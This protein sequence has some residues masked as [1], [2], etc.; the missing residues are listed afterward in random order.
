[1]KKLSESKSAMADPAQWHLSRSFAFE[2]QHVA[3]DVRGNGPAVVL[4]HGT[5]WSSFNWRK[6]I[7]ALARHH[8]VYFY[9]LLGFGQSQKSAGQDVSLRI[10]GRLL[11]RLI[12]HWGL[13]RPMVVG[14]DFGGT[15][16]LRS[17]LLEGIE[18][19]KMAL[20]DPVAV[21]PWGSPF[22]KH[23]KVH[24]A[25]FSGVPSYIH[26][27]MVEAYVRGAMHQTPQPEALAGILRP[28]LSEEGQAAFYRQI[29]QADQQY[30]DEI[31]PLYGAITCK[32]LLVWGEE[33][34][35]VPI[36]KGH[37]LNRMIPGSRL[38]PLP[39]A[40]HLVQEDAPQLLADVLV[41]YFN[42]S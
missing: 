17:H 15:T 10:Q 34:T 4:V 11:A 19:A 20:V 2:A 38:V 16:V 22:F 23:V 30:T 39:A 13:V 33:D 6:I 26:A 35:W 40:G 28:W 37:A 1:M 3:Y 21:G 9:D 32:P 27:A 31:E 18:Y 5:P 29:S 42:P 41:K 12:E 14:H 24:E 36:E 25:A 7:A 8:T